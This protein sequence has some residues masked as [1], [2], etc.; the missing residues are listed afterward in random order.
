MAGRFPVPAYAIGWFQVA[1]SDELSA[2]EVRTLHYFGR[3][4]V[5][6]RDRDGQ[7]VLCDAY[8]PH[9]GAHLG[10]GGV[11]TDDGM[12]CP[13]HGWLFDADG[14]CVAVPAGAL[15]GPDGPAIDSVAALRIYPTIET[16]SL[17]LAW[18]HP[19]AAAPGF[20]IPGC[21]LIADGTFVPLDRRQWTARTIW[22]EA[23]ESIL[24]LTHV[25][26]LHGLEPY[27]RHEMSQDGPTR[28]T[29]MTQ[30]LR[31]P[32]GTVDLTIEID[33]IGPGYVITKIGDNLIVIQAFSPVDE[34]LLDVR[35][36]FFGRDLGAPRRTERV[37][38]PLIADLVRQT[39][40][41]VT[42]W[43]HKA[44]VADPPLTPEDGPIR[45][46]RD[47]AAQFYPDQVD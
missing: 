15:D 33:A 20:Q 10:F 43:S 32:L 17:V 21:G 45:P 7:V 6:W 38:A 4:L 26:E 16:D 31:T 39:E 25:S 27:R 13:L 44:Y 29:G 36:T 19:A 35:F 37:A 8:C 24:D 41:H 3:D 46:F 34:E 28:H 1:Y 5:L 11:V 2:G 18:F 12:R 40:Q 22:Q 30:P 47:W 23:A 14:R 42:I 9:L